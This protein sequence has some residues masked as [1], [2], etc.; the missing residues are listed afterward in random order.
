M[1]RSCS[2]IGDYTSAENPQLRSAQLAKL[3][4]DVKLMMKTEVGEAFEPYVPGSRIEQVRSGAMPTAGF[5]RGTQVSSQKPIDQR[6][7][8][9]AVRPSGM[10]ERQS[11]SRNADCDE[12]MRPAARRF[13]PSSGCR[14]GP[15]SWPNSAGSSR[16]ARGGWPCR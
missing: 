8:L 13:V 3:A 4:T 6:T 1:H 2:R 15:S 14:S 10:P 11:Q 9:P 12:A 5:A 7:L 16:L